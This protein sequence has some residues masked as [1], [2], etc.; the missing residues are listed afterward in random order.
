MRNNM[1]MHFTPNI[2]FPF[3]QKHN[4]FFHVTSN[5]SISTIKHGSHLHYSAC[6]STCQKEYKLALQTKNEIHKKTCTY[7][8]SGDKKQ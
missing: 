1:S 8:F 2:P 4:L 6:T 5:T 3:G 7:V